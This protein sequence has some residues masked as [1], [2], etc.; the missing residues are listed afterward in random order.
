MSR[1]R[2]TSSG[3]TLLVALICAI[4]LPGTAAW[5]Q[6]VKATVQI[7]TPGEAPMSMGLWASD[8][9]VRIDL[10][11]QN[12]SVV[13]T[14]GATPTMLMIQH[15]ERSYIEMGTQQLEM[16]RQ[17]MQRMPNAGGGGGDSASTNLDSVRFEPTGQT[18]TIGP[19]SASEV[20]VTGMPQ[21]QN[22]TVWVTSELDVGLFELFA[23]MGDALEAM[24][25]PMLGGGGEGPQQQLMRYRQ[26]KDAAGLPSGGVVRLNADVTITLQDV[27]QGPFSDDPYAGP[28][29]YEKTEMPNVGFPE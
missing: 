1:T 9:G 15:N 4:A 8:Q 19:W 23:R 20:R 2:V 26:M 13:L 29:G 14:S 24:Q 11:Q 22:G 10:P 5:A 17:L 28:P 6:D 12:V 18:E 3:R 7:E 25:M 27:E 21:G 16:M